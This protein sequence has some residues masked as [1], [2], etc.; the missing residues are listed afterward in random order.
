MVSARYWSGEAQRQ[1]LWEVVTMFALYFTGQYE[2][3]PST[4]Q[5]VTKKCKKGPVTVLT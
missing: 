4:L 3:T 1:S 2:L 5:D